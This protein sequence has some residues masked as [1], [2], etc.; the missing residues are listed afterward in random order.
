M[1]L[2]PLIVTVWAAAPAV[3][4]VGEMLVI[5]G[6]G[7]FAGAVV[8]V[9][10]LPPPQAVRLTATAVIAR[11]RSRCMEPSLI[12]NFGGELILHRV[13]WTMSE[14]FL[15][16]INKGC[17]DEV[18]GTTFRVSARCS[19]ERPTISVCQTLIRKTGNYPFPDPAAFAVTDPN[20]N[21]LIL[22]Q[23]VH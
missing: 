7:L 8:V 2:A 10:L 15:A 23:R 9:E 14:I 17:S 11:N 19:T 4:E 5:V 13:K 16:Q 22:V 21:R 1:K 20:S 12:L 18:S 3:L 6:I